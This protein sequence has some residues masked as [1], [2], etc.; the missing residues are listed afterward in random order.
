MMVLVRVLVMIVKLHECR[1]IV[2]LRSMVY[3]IAMLRARGENGLGRL[4]DMTKAD[5]WAI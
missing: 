1:M 4:G 2:H 3:C 5:R